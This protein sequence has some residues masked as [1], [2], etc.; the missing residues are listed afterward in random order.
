MAESD[1]SPT[2][3]VATDVESLHKRIETLSSQVEALN[4]EK[5]AMKKTLDK[6]KQ[7]RAEVPP[8]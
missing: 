7:Q 1:A 6:T 5:K 4:S 8:Q 2:P 3:I